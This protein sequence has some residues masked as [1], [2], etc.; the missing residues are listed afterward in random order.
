M[1][2]YGIIYD[3]RLLK[4]EIYM[5]YFS[6]LSGMGASF[7]AKE[8]SVKLGNCE[9]CKMYFHIHPSAELL[10]VVKGEMTVNILGK[11]PEKLKEGECAL[12]FPFQSHSYDR[13][14]GTE[15]YRFHFAPS[16]AAAFFNPNKNNVG[17]RAVFSINLKEYLPFLDSIK[18]R[19]VSL[20]KAKGFLYNII[21]DYSANVPLVKKHVGDDV[22]SKVIS[23]VNDHKREPVTLSE[24]A[25]TL[26]YNEKYLSRSINNAAGFNFSTL[27]STLRMEAASLLLK[28]T[29]RTVVDIAIEC[30]FG[31]ER[32]FYRRFKENTGYTPNEFR[33]SPPANSGASD[34]V[35]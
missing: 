7:S 28:T 1:T 32:N 16:I 30:G 33:N 23:Y 20:Y 24:V 31:S 35:L 4:Q 2:T 19:N 9:E 14:E 3:K 8:H 18:E 17:E 10:L 13:P 5:K 29:D 25:A 6:T 11:E 21:G 15:Y 34:I 22:L 26:G 12:M 27:L